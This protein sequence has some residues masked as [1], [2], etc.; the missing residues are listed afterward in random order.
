MVDGAFSSSSIGDTSTLVA[1]VTRL[2]LQHLSGGDSHHDL[3]D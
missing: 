2:H 1:E 3:R